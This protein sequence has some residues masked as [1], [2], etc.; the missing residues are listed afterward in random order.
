MTPRLTYSDSSGT[1][2]LK[3]SAMPLIVALLVVPIVLGTLLGVVIDLGIGIGMAAGAVTVAVLL[4]LAARALPG[5]SLEVAA[6]RDAHR[7]LLVLAT[8]EATPKAAEEIAVLGGDAADVRLVVPLP[9]T[10]LER[11]LSSEDAAREE[12]QR[13][14]AHSAGALVAAGLPVSGSLGDSDPVQ[15]LEDELRSFSADQVV[16]L[17]AS[18]AGD[19]LQGAI[20][21]LGVPLTRIDAC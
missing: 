19:P 9:S 16:V 10:R 1:T 3:S 4:I 11:W 7:R 13:R 12:A 6:R 18:G 20:Q 14:L 8:A 15:A 2:R 21:R 17:S 5:G